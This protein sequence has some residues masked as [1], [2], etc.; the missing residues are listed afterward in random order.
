MLSSS[1]LVST[2]KIVN[3]ESAEIILMLNKEF[4]RYARHTDLDIY[5]ERLSS[6]M[7]T[8]NDQDYAQSNSDVY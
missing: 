6:R 1:I 4:N 8:L 2:E 7:D 3:N 5:S